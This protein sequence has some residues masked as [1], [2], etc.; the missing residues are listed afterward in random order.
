MDLD[1]C[2]NVTKICIKK[3]R[4]L[5]HVFSSPEYEINADTYAY[6]RHSES[7]SFKIKNIL[8]IIFF[9][10]NFNNKL[11]ILLKNRILNTSPFIDS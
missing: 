10:Y 7:E 6:N 5:K 4:F 3:Y 11:R 1:D 9:I 2:L 8:D